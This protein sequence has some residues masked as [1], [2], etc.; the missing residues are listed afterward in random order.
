LRLLLHAAID[1]LMIKNLKETYSEEKIK[2]VSIEVVSG[3]EY[4]ALQKIP[5][6]ALFGP[7]IGS[8]EVPGYGMQSVYTIVRRLSFQ[9]IQVHGG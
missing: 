6:R 8:Y 4:F 1:T 7:P 9:I 2:A 3:P 5:D